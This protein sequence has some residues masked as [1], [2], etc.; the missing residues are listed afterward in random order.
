MLHLILDNES[1]DF[2]TSEHKYKC[3]SILYDE[4]SLNNSLMKREFGDIFGNSTMFN[5]HAYQV[6]VQN[7]RMSTY[8][9]LEILIRLVNVQQDVF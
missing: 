4:L 3:N 5:S 8:R 1:R 2:L 9:V 6:D 7:L